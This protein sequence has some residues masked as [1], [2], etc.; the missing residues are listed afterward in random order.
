[1]VV[2]ECE[3]WMEREGVGGKIRL[4][5]RVRVGDGVGNEVGEDWMRVECV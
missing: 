2:R 4:R 5:G 1:M 3:V